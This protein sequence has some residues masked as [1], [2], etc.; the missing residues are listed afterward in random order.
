MIAAVNAVAGQI[1]E[2]SAVIFQI[3]D[4]SRY[5]VEALSYQALPISGSGEGR[6][7]DGRVL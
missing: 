3:I 6:L 4:P 1:A 7:S 2:P 5:W